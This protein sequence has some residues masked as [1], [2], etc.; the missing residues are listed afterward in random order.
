MMNN[1]ATSPS[2]INQFA[3]YANRLK[4]E[5]SIRKLGIFF[6]VLSFVVQIIASAFPAEKSLAA[7]TNDIISN[8]V[9]S[10]TDL[11][12]KCNSNFNGV[13]NIYAKFG[14]S[15][16]DINDTAK[17]TTINSSAYNFWSMGRNPLSDYGKSSEDWG[18]RVLH[19]N[20]VNIYHRP[21]KA[22]GANVNYSAFNVKSN[23]KNYWIIKDCGNLVTVGPEG[24]T[25][26]LEV[27]KSL[28]D[29]PKIVKPGDTVKF[30]VLYRNNVSESVA[31]DF[32]LRDLFDNANMTLVGMSGQKNDLLN[33]DP[34]LERKGLG[35]TSTYYETTVV[36]KVKTSVANG[37]QIC[38]T[39][40]ASADVVGV[41]TSNKVCVTVKIDTPPPPVT[42][43]TEPACQYNASLKASDS[44][45]VPPEQ[46]CQYDASLKASDEK[47]ARCTVPGLQ[48]I[49]NKDAKCVYPAG[50]ACIA[51]T[52]FLGNSNK[53][54]IVY[55]EATV[56]GTTKATAYDYTIDDATKP[57]VIHRVSS[58]SD[59]A[60]FKNLSK[61]THKFKVTV[62]LTNSTQST[63]KSCTSEI[64]IAEDAKLVQ[65]KSVTD[66]K[67]KNMDGQKVSSGQTLIF[68]LTTKNVTSTDSP[69]F[70][71][72]DYFGDVMEYAD[73]VDQN[74]LATQGITLDNNKYFR[75]TTNTIKGN[76]TD[77]KTVT[78]KV[79]KIV[80][81]TNK[82]STTTTDQDCVISNKY[83]NQVS[84]NVNC[85]LVKK[86]ETTATSLPNTGPGTTVGLAFIVTVVAAYFFA[87]ARL[88]N[89]E[90]S[91][92]KNIYQQAI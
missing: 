42:P 79:K 65:S 19:V 2:Y 46:V 4:K 52:A 5:E 89:K 20:G 67:G 41:K 60:E 17:A 54:V 1:L 53:D 76:S 77:T 36:G 24:P 51:S 74:Q 50:G 33:G 61:G 22:W 81:S 11:V 44:R 87:R 86:L 26:N 57:S 35:F 78:V 49:S 73:I 56:E 12:S 92:V 27:S 38:N 80:P 68:K 58:L 39:A 70:S 25:P 84:V 7:S 85:P 30:K 45:C 23:N 21:L 37:T 75:W 3:F 15:C 63:T 9:A 83:G 32:R 48:G 29:T 8:G 64:D 31:V 43:P 40:N 66:D 55:A 10:K 28:F 14:V 13:Q 90:A 34:Y 16:K 18:E 82:P 59:S 71:G 72:E 69:S 47:C 62:Y 91:L 6:I 88:L